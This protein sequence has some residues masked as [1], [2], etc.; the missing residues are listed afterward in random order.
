MSKLSW[1]W[2]IVSALGIVGVGWFVSN[3]MEAHFTYFHEAEAI[4]LR[5]NHFILKFSPTSCRGRLAKQDI[6]STDLDRDDVWDELYNIWDPRPGDWTLY[7]EE[8]NYIAASYPIVEFKSK[9]AFDS[10]PYHYSVWVTNE[11]AVQFPRQA[12]GA[13]KWVS[14]LG[15]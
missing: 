13:R 5:D 14:R 1:A 4:Q 12:C 15:R 7:R 6:Y 3:W 9:I 10:Y 11:V 8:A 2:I